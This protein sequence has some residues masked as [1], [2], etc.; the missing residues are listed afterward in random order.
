MKLKE[1]RL[2][3]RYTQADVARLIGVKSQ[4]T[5]SMWETGEMTPRPDKLVKLAT[6][7][8]CTVDDLLRKGK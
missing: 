3:A 5:V 4:S 2:K 7:F 6:L 8:H 1:M